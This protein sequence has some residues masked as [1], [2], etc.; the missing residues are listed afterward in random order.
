LKN[1]IE[2]LFS[3]DSTLCTR[4]ATHIVFRRAEQKSVSI[5]IISS[6]SSDAVREEKLKGFKDDG[7]K[8]FFAKDFRRMLKKICCFI[9]DMNRFDA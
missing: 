6:S 1:L 9:R 7:L 2:L 4:F 5:S 8:T 3:R